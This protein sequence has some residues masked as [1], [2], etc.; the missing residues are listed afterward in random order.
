MLGNL[1][2]VLKCVGIAIHLEAPGPPYPITLICQIL[3]VLFARLD[4]DAEIEI[5]GQECNILA[6]ACCSIVLLVTENLSLKFKLSSVCYHISIF[7]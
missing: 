5:L 2:R 7:L 6:D 4:L 3:G 1:I